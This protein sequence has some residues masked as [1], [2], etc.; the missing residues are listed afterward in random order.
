MT[1]RRLELRTFALSAQRSNQLSYTVTCGP[2]RHFRGYIIASITLIRPRA[3]SRTSPADF[4]RP[5]ARGAA[6]HAFSGPVNSHAPTR[7][8]SA[9]SPQR[10]APPRSPTSTA[11]LRPR[12]GAGGP[13]DRRDAWMG[14][15]G[16]R[17]ARRGA[18][19]A[20]HG[21]RRRAAP[22]L[23]AGGRRGRAGR[24]ARSASPG[25]PHRP[26]PAVGPGS[27]RPPR[28]GG[29]GGE[30]AD[31]RGPPRSP[32]PCPRR[33]PSPPPWADRPAA[34]PGAPRACGGRACRAAGQERA[35]GSRLGARGVS[36]G[37]GHRGG[38][39]SPPCW[40]EVLVAPVSEETARRGAGAAY[41]P[42]AP[43]LSQ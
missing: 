37:P 17:R 41:I 36:R 43:A 16:A 13:A 2:S 22:P 9:P 19:I 29:E 31:P 40:W 7:S 8:T 18:G 14:A 39:G 24:P 42:R 12:R 26:G 20:P 15:R 38:A 27:T 6:R 35:Q 4:A 11:R 32:R 33:L 1:E 28:S 23:L 25:P 21:R 3:V 34:P 5:G 30:V 10:P